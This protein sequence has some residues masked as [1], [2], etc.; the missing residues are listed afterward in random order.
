MG[1]VEAMPLWLAFVV[2]FCIVAARVQLTYWAGR[3]ATTLGE[4]RL[5]FVARIGTVQRT[6]GARLIERYGPFAVT[7][8]FLT[9]G[10]QTAVNFLAGATRM[11][12]GRYLV[13]MLIGSALWAVIWTVGGLGVV[14]AWL[15]LSSRAPFLAAAVVVVAVVGIVLLIRRR[16]ALNRT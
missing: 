16:R 10:L 13:S 6:R 14:W 15:T 7:L 9:V 1:F 11:P 2:M 12:F 4:R 8:S 5:N 3:G